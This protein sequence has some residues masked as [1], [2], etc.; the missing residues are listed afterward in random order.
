M[1]KGKAK[2]QRKRGV[3]Y[4]KHLPHGFY[5][6]ELRG[7]F[8]QFGAITRVRLARSTRTLGSK[9]YAFI[10]FRYP[11]VAEIAAEAM[12]NYLMFKNIIKTRYIPPNEIKHD[13][14]RSGVKKVKKDG[15]KVLT[16]TA[17]EAREMIV[18]NTNRLMTTEDETKRNRKVEKKIKNSAKKL[19]DLGIEYD[20]D[21]INQSL[22][23]Q[24]TKSQDDLSQLDESMNVSQID[25]NSDDEFEDIVYA[26]DVEAEEDD[27][28]ED[29]SDGEVQKVEAIS[30]AKAARSKQDDDQS[31]K[32]QTKMPKGKE[33]EAKASKPVKAKNNKNSPENEKPV[34]KPKRNVKNQ[35]KT[36][37]NVKSK[38]TETLD[39][40][41][42]KKT[43]ANRAKTSKKPENAQVEPQ[44]E[45]KQQQKPKKAAAA[46]AQVE[47]QP[48]SKQQKP[49]R[50]TKAKGKTQ[51]TPKPAEVEMT[52]PKE[53]KLAKKSKTIEKKKSPKIDQKLK[54]VAKSVQDIE[55]IDD[56]AKVV[57]TKEVKGK[58]KG[59]K[60]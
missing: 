54:V 32:S 13:Y 52:E 38:S 4:I 2:K 27:D 59:A 35:A 5:E 20:V 6:D 39:E 55:A 41:P 33:N 3:L 40:P 58:K 11:E 31:K 45:P 10:E 29:E 48:E 26:S 7:Y 50:A 12:N 15:V 28:T 24:A 36:A 21:V 51:D 16:S 19:E 37:E 42:Q 53:K 34:E 57:K 22:K 18:E 23:E 44:P 9:G 14:F 49:V 8:S 43:K 46:K 17:I 47:K 56:I 1:K 30:K 25:I 60:K